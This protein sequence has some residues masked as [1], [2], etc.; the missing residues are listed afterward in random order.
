MKSESYTKKV[1]V[2]IDLHLPESLV[3]L[4]STHLETLIQLQYNIKIQL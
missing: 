1:F 4:I 2:L 3:L